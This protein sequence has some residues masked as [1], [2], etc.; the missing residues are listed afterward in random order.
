M[1]FALIC[2]DK[3]GHL[4]LRLDTR[5]DHVVFL[6]DLNARGALKFGGPFLDADGKPEGSL[7][8]IEAA[9]AAVAQ[10]IADADPYAKAGLFESVQVRPWNWVFNNPASA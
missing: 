10:A 5:P 8:V 2:K 4:Q 7:V 9:D 6:N 1:L 3:P